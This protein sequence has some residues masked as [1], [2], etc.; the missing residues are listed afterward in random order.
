MDRR[1]G[2]RRLTWFG[3]NR[4][5]AP[6]TPNT[7]IT[8]KTPSTL[9]RMWQ[10]NSRD[11]EGTDTWLVDESTAPGKQTSQPPD[12]QSLPHLP[13]WPPL[14]EDDP[15]ARGRPI[16]ETRT[17]PIGSPLTDQ[18]QPSFSDQRVGFRGD[19]AAQ[20]LRS[21][22][23]RFWS[24]SPRLRVGVVAGA[25]TIVLC[26]LLGAVAL[27]NAFLNSVPETAKST[28][29][30]GGSNVLVISPSA[31]QITPSV[32]TT[33]TVVPANTQ[34]PTPLIVTFTCSSGVAGGAGQVCVH[35]L[36]NAA[37]SLS[38]RYCDSSYAKGKAFHGA[39]FADGNGDYTWRWDVN[40]SCIGS[41]TATVVAK[42][43]GQTVT[44]SL[45]FT[46]TK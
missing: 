27:G 12:W 35:T 46:I 32:T 43:A 36:P 31:G 3:N 23:R 1:P 42:S 24:K 41:A 34:P 25:A 13:K 6:K 5:G 2:K 28:P 4:P 10:Q 45:T 40:T 33:T 22:L 30:T 9:G 16:E 15:F 20:G 21:L 8:P 37:L 11:S 7:P 26:L 19:A 38:V 17:V 39:N 14:P 44:Q 18:E 29:G